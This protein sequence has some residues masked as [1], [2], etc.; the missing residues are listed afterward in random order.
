MKNLL[1]FWQTL[2]Q[3]KHRLPIPQKP[4]KSLTARQCG[5]PG[6]MA[7]KK[8]KTA[9][10]EKYKATEARYI[11][12]LKENERLN[13]LCEVLRDNA[14]Q[15]YFSEN[16]GIIC[17]I[18]NRYAGK[19]HG[20]K[21]A[22]K[23]RSEIYNAIGSRCYIRNKYDTAEIT[24]YFDYSTRYP[25]RELVFCPIW[26]GEN[27]PALVNNRVQTITAEKM[28]VYCCGEYTEDPEAHTAAVYA[29]HAAAKEAEKAF[30]EAVSNYNK[31]CR[32]NMSHASTREGVKSWII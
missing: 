24:V 3:Q 7:P 27:K 28:R 2:P 12:E 19:P 17:D 29:A 26:E 31:L 9:A 6:R 23:I 20:E 4:K 16:I 18:W 30:E 11:E 32:G 13:V 1:I 14:A 25:F 22:E 15:A 10:Y 5:K 8:K 21:T